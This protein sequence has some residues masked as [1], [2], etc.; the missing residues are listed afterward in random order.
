LFGCR[1]GMGFLTTCVALSTVWGRLGVGQSATQALWPVQAATTLSR[2]GST[3]F[4]REVK[5]HWRPPTAPLS[6][7][8]PRQD[9]C[10]GKQFLLPILLSFYPTIFCLLY[11]TQRGQQVMIFMDCFQERVMFFMD[12]FQEC[13]SS[14]G[15]GG[16]A[17]KSSAAGVIASQ[18]QCRHCHSVW[19][20]ARLHRSVPLFSLNSFIAN[21]HHRAQH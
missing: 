15:P 4:C 12:C 9:S 18:R 14:V 5:G 1:T 11:C 10:E 20:A 16:E 19:E 8:R 21:E 17:D 6:T 7:L 3:V 2:T 13:V